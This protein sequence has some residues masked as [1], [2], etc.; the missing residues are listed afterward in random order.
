MVVYINIS[1]VCRSY[2]LEKDRK[3]RN[4]IVCIFK[5]DYCF[6]IL[7]FRYFIVCDFIIG[8]KIVKKK[9]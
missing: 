5:I 6:D 8:Y 9:K 1:Y 3:N 7:C 4:I 2:V